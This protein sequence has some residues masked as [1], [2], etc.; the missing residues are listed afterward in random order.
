VWWHKDERRSFEERLETKVMNVK[1]ER[2][3]IKKRGR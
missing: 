3:Y 1:R 2:R